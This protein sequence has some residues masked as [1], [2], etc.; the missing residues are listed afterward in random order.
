MAAALSLSSKAIHI[1][2]L[3]PRVPL[4]SPDTCS[5]GQRTLMSCCFLQR[6]AARDDI[7]GVGT[8]VTVINTRTE[9]WLVGYGDG[10]GVFRDCP[11]LDTGVLQTGAI[12]GVLLC[13]QDEHG[14][15]LSDEDIR[16]EAD[17][18]MF[19]G[20]P[21]V[22]C[23]REGRGLS[24]HPGDMAGRPWIPLFLPLPCPS[25]QLHFLGTEPPMW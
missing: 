13:L 17:T 5:A 4:P 1:Q 25:W 11:K 12:F 7:I 20:E 19:G 24:G 18:F 9:L 23:C 10:P 6:P 16:A 21:S 22:N 15:A 2:L 8:L 3:Y 14:K